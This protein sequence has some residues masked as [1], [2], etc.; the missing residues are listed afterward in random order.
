MQKSALCEQEAGQSCAGR[1]V[2]VQSGT[3]MEIRTGFCNAPQSAPCTL[4]EIKSTIK[5]HDFVLLL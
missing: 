3:G 2:A 1:V 4:T 5:V